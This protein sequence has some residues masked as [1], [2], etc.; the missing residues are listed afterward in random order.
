MSSDRIAYIDNLKGMLILLVVIGH[1]YENVTNID[2]SHTALVIYNFIY[3]F[4]MPLFLFCSGLFAAR[5][6]RNGRG[7]AA[8]NALLYFA[9][10][11]IFY[12]L[13]FVERHAIGAPTEFNPLYVSSG[14]WYLLVLALFTALTPLLARMKFFWALIISLILSVASGLFNEDPTFL[15][16]S[17]FFTYLPWYVLGF[18]TT[19]ETVEKIHTLLRDPSTKRNSILSSLRCK[20][21]I[22]VSALAILTAYFFVTFFLPDGPTVLLRRL[23]TGLHPFYSLKEGMDLS[24]V[25]MIFCRIAHYGLVALLCACIMALVPARKSFLTTVGERT[26]QIYIIHLLL[27]YYCRTTSIDVFLL[28]TIPCWVILGPIIEGTAF[29][30]I[31]AMPPQPNAWVKQLKTLCSRVLYHDTEPERLGRKL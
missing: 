6:F 13:G 11:L 15:S 4:H 29:T 22:S 5:S 12:I 19:S 17:R 30:A 26:L 27:I 31:L 23:S 3:A 8:E 28:E 7:F 25:P 2:A 14:A 24:A 21:L 16:S 20:V 1:F 9:L 18:Y 10:Y